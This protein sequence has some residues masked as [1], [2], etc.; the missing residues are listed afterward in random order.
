MAILCLLGVFIINIIFSIVQMEGCEGRPDIAIHMMV[1]MGMAMILGCYIYMGHLQYYKMR[2]NYDYNK[3]GRRIGCDRYNNDKFFHTIYTITAVILSTCATLQGAYHLYTSI[4]IPTRCVHP[5]STLSREFYWIVSAGL[6]ITGLWRMIIAVKTIALLAKIKI[7][8]AKLEKKDKK[9]LMRLLQTVNDARKSDH[10]A[11]TLLYTDIDNYLYPYEHL[12]LTHR[13]AWR[14]FLQAMI[15][16]CTV[17]T[18]KIIKEGEIINAMCKSCSY[19]IERSDLVVIFYDI[20]TIHHYH[21][22]QLNLSDSAYFIDEA[23]S[24]DIY[25]PEQ[26]QSLA[27]AVSRIEERNNQW[28]IDDIRRDRIENIMK[29]VLIVRDADCD[30]IGGNGDVA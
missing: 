21:C 13:Y 23:D 28:N 19:P 7:D 17:D 18:G 20:P 14:I 22:V 4:I 6:A 24:L 3:V 26:Q 2:N 10:T 25:W 27:R 30:G 1:G 16:I 11:V 5:P 29:I 15:N 12:E 8:K 9:Q